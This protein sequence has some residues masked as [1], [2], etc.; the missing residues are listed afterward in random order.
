MV[1]IPN[2]LSFLRL[3]LAFLFIQEGVA[4]RAVVI[5]IVAI[6]DFFDG[7]LARQRK[8]VSR[9][10]T[11]LDPVSDKFFV[12]MALGIFFAEER[13]TALQIAAMLC[14]DFAIILFGLY[15]VATKNFGKYQFR[16]I[17]CGKITTTL[18]LLTLVALT[19]HVIVPAYLYISF[20]ILGVTALIELYSSNHTLVP[21]HPKK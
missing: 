21:S 17:W 3:P 18:Q 8:Q 9:F 15:L 2:I 14:R 10:G 5:V 19:F 12:M 11:I 13:I 6:T 4:I 16:S 20:V 1:N 7:Y